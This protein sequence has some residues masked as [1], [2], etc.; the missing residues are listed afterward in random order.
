MGEA[1]GIRA[2]K[3]DLINESWMD[4]FIINEAGSCANLCDD[5]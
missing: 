4:N 5:W 2:T 3:D 1:I